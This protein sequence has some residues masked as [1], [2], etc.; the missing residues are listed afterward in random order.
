MIGEYLPCTYALYLYKPPKFKRKSS[1]KWWSED[2]FPFGSRLNFRGEL[3]NLQEVVVF[4]WGKSIERHFPRNI[5][6]GA[7]FLL[8]LFWWDS[9]QESVW[10][11]WW[12]CFALGTAA[13]SR[14]VE[15]SL[16]GW[17][18]VLSSRLCGVLGGGRSGQTTSTMRCT[19]SLLLVNGSGW[20]FWG[21]SGPDLQGAEV[22]SD[23][24][25]H[26]PGGREHYV[27]CCG[28]C[29]GKHE[30]RFLNQPVGAAPGRWCAAG[31]RR[32]SGTAMM[33]MTMMMIIDLYFPLIS[34]VIDILYML[35]YLS[36]IRLA[37]VSKHFNL[38]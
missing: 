1:E 7:L 10:C 20:T 29:P 6:A 9:K 28:R 36:Y 16:R 33:M 13:W 32:S 5:D 19:G 34:E 3:I 23:K 12:W 31:R 27:G 2:H 38:W 4:F 21:W 14:Y 37:E 15:G 17:T 26:N 22:L 24:H 11:C 35:M 25:D 18:Y 30:C 8:P